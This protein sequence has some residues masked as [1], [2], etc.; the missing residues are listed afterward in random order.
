M[1]VR[2]FKSLLFKSTQ[3]QQEIENEQATMRPDRWRLIKLKK[4][5]LAMKDQMECLVHFA[6]GRVNTNL[7]PATIAAKNKRRFR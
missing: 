3:I 6:S 7:Q 1:S 4:L 2:L 5:R